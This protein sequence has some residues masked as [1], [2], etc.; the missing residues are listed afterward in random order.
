VLFTAEWEGEVL[1]GC[2]FIHDEEN[3]R[4]LVGA[5]KRLEVDRKKATLIGNANRL[6]IWEAIK[7]AKERGIKEFDLGGYSLEAES[8][9]ND[10]RYGINKFKKSFGGK[11]VT[12]YFYY[13]DCSKK[14][15]FFV[16]LISKI[17]D[18]APVILGI[19]G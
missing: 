13:K 4:W 16:R 3:I 11:L 5:S 9:P 6:I 8:N 19:R 18:V 10:P 12:R 2:Y 14:L 1:G 15:K 17:S 7:W